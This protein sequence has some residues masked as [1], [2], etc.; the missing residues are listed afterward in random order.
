VTGALK[1]DTWKDRTTGADRS[2]PVIRVDRLDLLG[3]KAD[4]EEG[5][6]SETEEF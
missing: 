3:S 1:F 4:K 6:G 2:S 5:A